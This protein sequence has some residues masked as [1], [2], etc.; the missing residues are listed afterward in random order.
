VGEVA[1]GV[2]GWACTTIR[3]VK[4]YADDF[5]TRGDQMA[6]KGRPSQ[7]TLHQHLFGVLPQNLH[8]DDSMEERTRDL[9]SFRPEADS[10]YD[11]LTST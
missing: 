10:L 2:K 3:R 8:I 4:K 9:H 11:K 1:K 6:Y 7:N 5:F